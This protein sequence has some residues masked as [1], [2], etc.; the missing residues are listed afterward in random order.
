MKETSSRGS[1]KLLLNSNRE[2]S[3]TFDAVKNAYAWAQNSG[4]KNSK[5]TQ[6][7]NNQDPLTSKLIF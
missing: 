4:Q 5:N 7:H 3:K 1:K 2:I 6:R